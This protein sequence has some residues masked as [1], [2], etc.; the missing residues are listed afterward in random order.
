MLDVNFHPRTPTTVT[1]A[2]NFHP[3]VYSF[4][5]EASYNAIY[6]VYLLYLGDAI[7]LA[8]ASVFYDF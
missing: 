7:F 6:E 8:K 1:C 4:H 5:F 2:N 3:E